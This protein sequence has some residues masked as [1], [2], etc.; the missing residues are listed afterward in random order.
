M[1]EDL[2]DPSSREALLRD[3]RT[4][5]RF[6]RSRGGTACLVQV[7]R[8]SVALNGHPLG[9]GDGAAV[10]EESAIVLAG[11]ETAEVLLFDLS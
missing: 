7:A 9:Q 4:R 2:S 1:A 10:S 3:P 11:R 5:R 8:G 6:P